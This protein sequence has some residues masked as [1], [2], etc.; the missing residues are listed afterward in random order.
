MK[1]LKRSLFTV[2]FGVF[3][4][5]ALTPA[6]A[7]MEWGSGRGTD[8]AEFPPSRFGQGPVPYKQHLEAVRAREEAESVDRM[9]RH[10]AGL[11]IGE[12]PEFDPKNPS[13]SSQMAVP[14]TTRME[15]TPELQKLGVHRKGVQE[16]SIIAG[17]LGFFPKTLFVNRDIPVRLY[18]TGA[19][20]NTLCLMMD[21]FTVRKQVKSQRIEEITFTPNEPGRY[22]FY[23]PING[24]EGHLIVRELSDDRVDAVT[25]SNAAP[26]A[27]NETSD[28][29]PASE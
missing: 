18:V 29:F 5:A 23:C 15:A 21:A 9:A 27:T 11:K 4:V 1:N 26:T 7:D 10:P 13:A 14:P 24:M 16:V 8:G 19:S 3:T 17:D 25:S 22:R 2:A 20:K 6:R 28:R 12:D